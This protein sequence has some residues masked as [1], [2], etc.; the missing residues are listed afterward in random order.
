MNILL[1]TSTFI[2]IVSNPQRLSQTARDICLKEENAL[3]L[4][5]VSGWEMMVKYHLHKL[6]LPEKPEIII[7][8]QAPRHNIQIIPLEMKEILQM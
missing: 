2:W 8:S 7:T 6:P 5:V 4:S 3:F 1:D